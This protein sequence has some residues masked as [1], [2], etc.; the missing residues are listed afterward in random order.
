MLAT[1]SSWDGPTAAGIQ[2]GDD[3]LLGRSEAK[4]ADTMMLVRIDPTAATAAVLSIPRD[5]TFDGY[6]KINS[7]VALGPENAVN[8]VKAGLGV[9]IHDF[10]LI[11]FSGFRKIIDSIDGVPVFFPLPGP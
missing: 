2:S 8:K 11:N 3:L 4:L 9:E 1:S 6:N 10:V 7:A 5:L